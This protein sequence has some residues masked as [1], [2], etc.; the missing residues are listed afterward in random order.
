M[1]DDLA[2]RI[3]ALVD[4]QLEQEPTGY[5]YSVGVER[6]RCGDEWHGLPVTREMRRMRRAYGFGHMDAMDGYTTD[7]DTSPVMCPGSDVQGP[8]RDALPTYRY[9]EAFGGATDSA[10]SDPI[11]RLMDEVHATTREMA[12]MTQIPPLFWGR[13]HLRWEAQ[14]GE[15][16]SPTAHNRRPP[17]MDGPYLEEGQPVAF[18]DIHTGERRTGLW[19]EPERIIAAGEP[20]RL[21]ARINEMRRELDL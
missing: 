13:G 21:L 18:E 4:E 14:V 11:R 16:E 7:T 9:P 19:G 12:I 5:D 15:P 3:A 2:A 1:T 20:Q 17:W 10:H 8:L 6:C